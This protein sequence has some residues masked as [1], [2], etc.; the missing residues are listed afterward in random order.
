MDEMQSFLLPFAVSARFSCFLFHVCAV[1]AVCC[2][3]N[4]VDSAERKVETTKE[5]TGDTKT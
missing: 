2:L 4:R 3:P 5:G 1:G